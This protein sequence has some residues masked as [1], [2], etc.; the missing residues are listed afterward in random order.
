MEK[1][2]NEV[3]NN[4]IE[5]LWSDFKKYFWII[6]AVKIIIGYGYRSGYLQVLTPMIVFT[7]ELLSVLAMVYVMG[8]YSYKFSGDKKKMWK[9]V[10]GFLWLGIVAIFIGYFAVKRERDAKL[11]KI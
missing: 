8:Y 3:A 2:I 1:Q 7:I 10:W 9:G 4:Q 6:F 11:Q 5:T